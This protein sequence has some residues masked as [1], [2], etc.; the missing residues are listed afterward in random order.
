MIQEQKFYI[1]PNLNI[2][3]WTGFQL[4]YLIMDPLLKAMYQMSLINRQWKESVDNFIYLF[5]GGDGIGD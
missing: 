5:R 4:M 2:W 1:I 3:I